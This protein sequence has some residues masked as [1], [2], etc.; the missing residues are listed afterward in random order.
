MSKLDKSTLTSIG[1]AGEVPETFHY[2][3][4]PRLLRHLA[5]GIEFAIAVLGALL[6]VLV[7][8]NSALRFIINSDIS[9]SLEIVTFLMLWV[10]F[11]GCAAAAA[12]RAHM[13]VTEIAAFILSPM[14]QRRLEVG[15]NVVVGAI[16]LSAV[17]YGAEISIH[18]WQQETTVLY[19]PVGFLYSAM[20]VGLFLTLVFVCYDIY[21]SYVHSISGSDGSQR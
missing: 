4:L 9:W 6:I 3:H 16:V 10:T 15:I 19:W 13:R 11:L 12:R 8:M 5:L 18:T 1:D 17:W 14:F 7:F 21:S 2:E 20:P